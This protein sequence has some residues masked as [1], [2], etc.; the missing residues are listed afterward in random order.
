M[1]SNYLHRN[2]ELRSEDKCL[3][4]G[5]KSSPSLEMVARKIARI[6]NLVIEKILAKKE[7]LEQKKTT[8]FMVGS[9][10]THNNYNLLE[11]NHY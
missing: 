9:P 7:R 8:E 3:K 6:V 5:E 4:R 11:N 1:Y 10:L 2:E